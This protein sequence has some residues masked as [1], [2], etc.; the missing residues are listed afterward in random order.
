MCKTSFFLAGE[1]HIHLWKKPNMKAFPENSTDM[2]EAFHFH[3]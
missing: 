2:V 3:Q 1:G